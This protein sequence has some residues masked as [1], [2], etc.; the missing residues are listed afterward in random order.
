M[1]TGGRLPRFDAVD[2]GL[3]GAAEAREKLEWEPL[4]GPFADH[5]AKVLFAHG[6]AMGTLKQNLVDRDLARY[7]NHLI[8]GDIMTYDTAT[9]Y[10]VLFCDVT[11]NEGE[12][13][14]HMPKVM[15]LLDPQDWLLLCDDMEHDERIA[16]VLEYADANVA[17]PLRPHDPDSKAM[18]L[19]K[20][21]YSRVL[22]RR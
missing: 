8:F 21:S 1:K 11:H 3:T 4:T 17:M 12:I 10:Q 7:V 22:G 18:V 6:G 14:R 20:G 5:H 16:M 13:R 9:R 15:E 19:A 2:H